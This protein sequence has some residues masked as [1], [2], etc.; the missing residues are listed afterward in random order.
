[1]VFAGPGMRTIVL[2]LSVMIVVRI[3]VLT[4]VPSDDMYRAVHG[5]VVELYR[6]L[7]TALETGGSGMMGTVLLCETLLSLLPIMSTKDMPYHLLREYDITPIGS[8]VMWRERRLS[9]ERFARVVGGILHLSN[10]A[11]HRVFVPLR[12]F[13]ADG[14]RQVIRMLTLLEDIRASDGSGTVPKKCAEILVK[15]LVEELV[16]NN[17]VVRR[18]VL[19]SSKQLVGNGCSV[20]SLITSAQYARKIF[21]VNALPQ[22]SR[23]RDFLK[24]A[25]DLCGGSL[26]SA[27]SAQVLATLSFVPRAVLHQSS[28]TFSATSYNVVTKCSLL[29][30]VARAR[31]ASLTE[32]DC[33]PLLRAV[34][35]TLLTHFA[36]DPKLSKKAV[37]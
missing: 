9:L 5:L 28:V 14:R 2:L 33:M 34:E 23:I 31:S 21:D 22:T 25:Q 26:L 1:M 20:H 4:Q 12:H 37:K 6:P 18:S 36:M 11:I 35:I 29:N 8:G 7:L 32:D 3:C 17:V 19:T 10:P 30:I 24:T 27:L 16:G 15:C 13:P